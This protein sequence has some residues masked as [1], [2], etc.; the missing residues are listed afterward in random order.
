[1]RCGMGA[2]EKAHR[3]PSA[4]QFFL[5]NGPMSDPISESG[6]NFDVLSL[7]RVV[8]VAPQHPGNIGA[9]ARA[10]KVMGLSDLALVTP[11]HFPSA[12]ATARASGADD[13]LRSARVCKT[14]DEAIGDCAL[15]IGTSA[16][17]RHTTWPLLDARA[18][19]GE[20]IGH[21]RSEQRV[22]LVFGRERSGLTNDEL[23]RCRIH[24][25]VPTNPDYASL[26]L[27]AAVQ[28]VSYELRMATGAT[29]AAPQAQE[30]VTAG[31]MEGLYDHWAQVLEASGFLDPDEPKLLM[32]RL[33]RLFNRAEPDR[34][35]L[36]ILRGALRSLDPRL[37][38]KG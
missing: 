11:Q 32:R 25:Q 36:N 12:E 18:A 38:R 17:P 9:A 34:T 16:R 26:N 20:A 22:A 19:A 33:R 15:A 21:A 35:E 10:M 7:L 8:L 28:V 24:L 1:M 13:V 23:D 14:L 4:L 29:V 5:D 37:E 27:A 3:V 6:S 2:A 30:P 31:D